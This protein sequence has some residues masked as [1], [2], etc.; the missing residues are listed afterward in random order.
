MIKGSPACEQPLHG[1]AAQ[2]A[3]SGKDVLRGR[4]TASR[5]RECGHRSGGTELLCYFHGVD[6]VGPDGAS[7]DDEG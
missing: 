5:G 1:R 6:R 7:R 4:D 2:P 3:P